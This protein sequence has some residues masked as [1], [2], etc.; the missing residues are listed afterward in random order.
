MSSCIRLGRLSGTIFGQNQVLS[1]DRFNLPRTRSF[2]LHIRFVILFFGPYSGLLC[3]Q[4][5]SQDFHHLFLT[6]KASSKELPGRNPKQ[7][8]NYD[9]LVK[10]T[11]FGLKFLSVTIDEAHEFRNVGGKHS[12]A[13]AI[14][15]KARARL[16]MSATPL[17]TSTK[18][19]F[20]ADNLFFFLR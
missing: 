12:A 10:K 15:D 14:L 3:A 17:Q 5:L 13:L 1:L 20:I 8:L 18:V 4:A 6:P 7:V 19:N 16:I 11:L 2:W 9:S